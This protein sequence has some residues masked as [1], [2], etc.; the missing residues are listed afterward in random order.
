[1]KESTSMDPPTRGQSIHIN[2]GKTDGTTNPCLF[3]KMSI[4]PGRFGKGRHNLIWYIDPLEEKWVPHGYA[5]SKLDAGARLDKSS[6]H[7]LWRW[8]R[9]T[10]SVLHCFTA[11]GDEL[12]MR[13]SDRAGLS[14]LPT[15]G[16]KQIPNI[17]L[18]V[19]LYGIY[20]WSRLCIN[21][22]LF[23]S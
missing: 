6:P 13:N 19:T 7:W 1:M 21:P 5:K 8:G 17:G 9:L 3:D 20:I 18:L 4:T 22:S 12:Q 11:L 23:L 14:P 15:L 16:F 10:T 2:F